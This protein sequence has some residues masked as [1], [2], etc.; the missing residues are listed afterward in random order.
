MRRPRLVVVG[1]G[2]AGM[3]VVEELLHVAPALYEIT[4]F[5]AEPHGNYNRILL[6]P[7]LAGE[8]TLSDIVLHDA[9]W[10]AARG[11]RLHA[12]TPVVAIDREWKTVTAADG[13]VAH[14]D[15]LLLATGS[16][17]IVLPVP[18]TDL[19]GVMTFRD[20]ADVQRMLGAIGHGARRAVVIGGGL[21]GL[22]AASGLAR[23]G[24]EVSVV[25][26]LAT[27]MERQLD[28]PAAA[29]LQRALERRG[30]KFMLERQ[31]GAI[32]GEDRV[33]AVRLEPAPGAASRGGV[34]LPADL[35]VMAVGIRPNI[36]LAQAAGLSCRRGVEVSDTLQTSD[37]EI[38]AVGECVEHRGATYGL[39]AP[40]FEQAK[41]CADRLARVDSALYEGSFT[42]TKLKVT[43]IEVYSAGDFQGDARTEALVFQDPAQGVYKKLVLRDDRIH[44]GVLVGDT[45]DGPWFFELLRE[46]TDVSDLR[47]HLLFGPAHVDESGHGSPQAAA[48]PQ[49]GGAGDGNAAAVRAIVAAARPSPVSYGWRAGPLGQSLACPAGDNLR[50]PRRDR[51]R[52]RRRGIVSIAPAPITANAA[53]ARTPRAAGARRRRARERVPPRR[54]P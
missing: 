19:A 47:E 52:A 14:Y 9:G 39:V 51:R 21:L 7:V 26:L 48:S 41:V 6:S 10:Y 45:A 13:T 1:N 24:M 18:G 50:L 16:V 54:M 49:A 17:P 12:G 32:L 40:L 3:R 28:A 2:M 8:K 36:A 29:L 34:E 44:G 5:G 35:V 4:V 43:G 15:R 53:A 27:L 23:R 46:G 42:A 11:I 31:T 30:L 33:R 22:E 37:P 20:V 38:Y 25:H